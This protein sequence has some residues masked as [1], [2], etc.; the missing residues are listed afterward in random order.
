MSSSIQPV[1][2]HSC[3]SVWLFD[4]RVGRAQWYPRSVRCQQAVRFDCDRSS[5]RQK[6]CHLSDSGFLRKVMLASQV[7]AQVIG[8]KWRLDCLNP[9]S[10]CSSS[11]FYRE[12]LMSIL[13]N[14]CF[15][16][17][18]RGEKWGRNI[19]SF[20][21]FVAS[22]VLAVLIPDIGQIIQVQY[23]FYVSI[24]SYVGAYL[25]DLISYSTGVFRSLEA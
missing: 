4:I 19:I 22:L 14:S 23:L 5:R 24:L 2:V 12:A 6:L 15:F 21:W 9:S 10:C 7:S 16:S 17:H 20:V 1:G 3:R 18:S 13:L 8:H 11:A 25:T